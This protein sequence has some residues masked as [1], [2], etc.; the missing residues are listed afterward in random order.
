LKHDGQL[1]SSGF[2]QVKPGPITLA[3]ALSRL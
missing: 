2:Y 1:Q 3:P